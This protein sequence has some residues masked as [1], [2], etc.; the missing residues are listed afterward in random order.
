MNLYFSDFDKERPVMQIHPT[1]VYEISAL[2][3]RGQT[4][5]RTTASAATEQRTSTGR[6]AVTISSQARELATSVTTSTSAVKAMY[7]TGQ[8]NIELNI[9]D[10]F[11][12]NN[13]SFDKSAS[14]LLLPTQN[15][16]DN[17]SNHISQKLA[18]LMS[19]Y[20]ISAAPETIQYDNRGTMILPD[21]YPYAEEFNKMLEENPALERE[22]HT[23]NALSSHYAGMKEAL[24]FQQEY[25]N[26]SQAEQNAILAKYSYLFSDSKPSADITLKFTPNGSLTINVNG[27]QLA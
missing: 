14:L 5:Q 12:S 17:L 1:S 20:S 8:G 10:Y 2:T 18:G 25:R 11:T 3:G 9:D 13:L 15:N 7:N 26:A 23:V 16:I 6:D 27:E 22:M 19:Q 24:A 4:E 21:D